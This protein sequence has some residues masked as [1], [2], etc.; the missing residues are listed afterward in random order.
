MRV[1][2]ISAVLCLV[3]SVRLNAQQLSYVPDIV[4]G[5]RSF[6]YLHSVS[7]P[8]TGKLRMN[9]L[10]LFDTEYRQDKNNLFFIRNGFSYHILKKI[11]LNGAA[12]MKNPGSFLTVAAQYRTGGPA[13]SFSYSI[14][15][16]YQKGFTLEQSPSFEHA[17]YLTS[18]LQAYLSLLAI[19]NIRPG[20]YQRGLQ[21]IRLGIKEKAMSYGMAVNLD[22]F[23]HSRKTL[24][25]AGFFIKHH[26]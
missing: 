5:H 7:Y 12:G 26:F 14:G 10:T 25:N 13:C 16:T 6:T 19:A 21:F 23:G 1:E 3:L 18:G 8:L 11:T 4:A 22:Q 2:K 24:E 9:N 17:P 15:A 20:E